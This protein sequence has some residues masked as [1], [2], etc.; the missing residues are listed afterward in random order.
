VQKPAASS[1]KDAG[2]GSSCQ[3]LQESKATA[4]VA[5]NPVANPI[6]G[7]MFN[8][9]RSSDGGSNGSSSSKKG[10]GASPAR[11][12][13][14]A[15]GSPK[16]AFHSPRGAGGTAGTK[17]PNASRL[18]CAAVAS[19]ASAAAPKSVVAAAV[20]EAKM[21]KQKQ[22]QG[23][24]Y[25]PKAFKAGDSSCS[26]SM[27]GM[28]TGNAVAPAPATVEV[29][30][31]RAAEPEVADVAHS[32]APADAVAAAT[33]GADA[34]FKPSSASVKGQQQQQS[35]KKTQPPCTA[36][37]KQQQQ[38]QGQ[39]PKQVDQQQ[40]QQQQQQLKPQ[41]QPQPQLKVDVGIQTPAASP[42]TSG[43]G[44]PGSPADCT[45]EVVTCDSSHTSS[46]NTCGSGRGP[47]HKG[48]KQA[49]STAAKGKVA[50][51]ASVAKGSAGK[52]LAA[53]TSSN[54]AHAPS[55]ISVLLKV[56][57]VVVLL[58]SGGLFAALVLT[59]QGTPQQAGVAAAGSLDLQQ[60][61]EKMQDRV[62]ELQWQLTERELQLATCASQDVFAADETQETMSDRLEF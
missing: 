17:A 3:P 49:T 37:K 29:A 36:V 14:A 55:Q 53:A 12:P 21:V 50:L 58:L 2:A 27:T 35:S 5:I 44:S 47:H 40:Q 18:G 13:K 62:A 10:H 45:A 15:A 60:Q 6:A 19:S 59:R 32:K 23:V 56:A 20:A 33:A 24:V 7:V 52:E 57:L 22:R 1:S 48:K 25:N 43:L 34:A 26:S 28:S 8:F 38:Q 39:Q 51:Q 9:G 41:S 11:S 54:A 42:K 30:A 46:S 61:L 16:G 4:A 31:V